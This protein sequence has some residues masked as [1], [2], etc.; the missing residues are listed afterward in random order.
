MTG[1]EVAVTCARDDPVAAAS[2]A[3]ARRDSTRPRRGRGR[4]SKGWMRVME[5]LPEQVIRKSVAGGGPGSDPRVTPFEV[6][7]WIAPKYGPPRGPGQA[8]SREFRRPP[9]RPAGFSR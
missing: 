1:P 6:V 8:P 5:H 3:T 2:T 7:R 9:G 4:T